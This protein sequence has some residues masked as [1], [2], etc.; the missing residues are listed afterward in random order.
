VIRFLSIRYLE[1]IPSFGRTS[2]CPAVRNR[3]V[4]HH[5]Q[6]LT[7]TVSHD[8]P[9]ICSLRCQ[10]WS[11]S[12]LASF[13]SRV[14]VG[15]WYMTT[16]E[17]GARRPVL[18]LSAGRHLPARRS[19]WS[20]HPGLVLRPAR[21]RARRSEA[22][23]CSSVS[24]SGMCNRA[25]HRTRRVHVVY[26]RDRLQSDRH[27][28]PVGLGQGVDDDPVAGVSLDR[29]T[30]RVARG[31]HSLISR[32][33]HPDSDRRVTRVDGRDRWWGGLSPEPL[34]RFVQRRS[35]VGVRDVCQ[36]VGAFAHGQTGQLC[37][38]ELGH[39]DVGVVS[40]SGDDRTL[41]ETIDDA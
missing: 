7:I 2:R 35:F 38:T 1:L 14:G 3:S 6:V 40:R 21:R 31:Q 16:K 9:N 39:H 22:H 17:A 10:R 12:R 11:T 25:W 27:H 41:R 19:E 30:C 18:S 4:V 24:I 15:A 32:R 26:Q 5:H 28:A 20:T 13:P 37:R 8:R 23:S 36:G 29:R 34:G 33:R